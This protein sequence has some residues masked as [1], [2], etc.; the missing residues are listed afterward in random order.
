MI[1]TTALPPLLPVVMS[2]TKLFV[3]QTQLS[4][5]SQDTSGE[6]AAQQPSHPKHVGVVFSSCIRLPPLMKNTPT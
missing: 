2:L 1:G 4:K 6:G 5:L 3:C